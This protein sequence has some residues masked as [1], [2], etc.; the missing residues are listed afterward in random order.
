MRTAIATNGCRVETGPD[1]A[2]RW[3]CEDEDEAR[4]AGTAGAGNG[5][6]AVGPG[7][8]DTDPTP[9]NRPR[10]RSEALGPAPDPLDGFLDDLCARGGCPDPAPN[11][12]APGRAAGKTPAKPGSA[13][14]LKPDL[15]NAAGALAAERLK[16]LRRGRAG[17]KAEGTGPER[18]PA[19]TGGGPRR[20]EA[21]GP[22]AVCCGT[23]ESLQAQCLEFDSGP[24]EIQGED[25]PKRTAT[26]K[27]GNANKAK[28][29]K[30]QGQD[31][32]EGERRVCRSVGPAVLRP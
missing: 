27:L 32:Q 15:P 3:V 9:W 5:G 29:G 7:P 10:T 24:E 16:K 17:E 2:P 20:G 11:S 14:P 19:Q 21:P 30:G 6:G 22:R 8:S 25:R 1:D 23:A 12:R 13:M 4:A 31:R 28:S 18:K 26:R